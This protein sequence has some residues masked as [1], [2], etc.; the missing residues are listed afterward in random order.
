MQERS[1]FPP[2][3]PGP[4]SDPSDADYYAA[5][6]AYFTAFDALLKVAKADLS[7]IAGDGISVRALGDWANDNCHRVTFDSFQAKDDSPGF[8]RMQV[9]LPNASRI[10]LLIMKEKK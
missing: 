7:L 4:V 3:L 10:V 9:V 1:Y 2:V 6:N 8:Q 5:R